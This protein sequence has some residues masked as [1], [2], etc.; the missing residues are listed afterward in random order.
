MENL[1]KLLSR[2][3]EKDLLGHESWFLLGNEQHK[4]YWYLSAGNC[5][6]G[7]LDLK[8]ESFDAKEGRGHFSFMEVD[9]LFY[10][11]GDT[12][13][14]VLIKMLTYIHDNFEDE[15][16]IESWH[17]DTE[18]GDK[19]KYLKEL[20]DCLGIMTTGTDNPDVSNDEVILPKNT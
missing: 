14:E 7:G 9:S 6:T 5:G 12:I 13:E 4:S 15:S 3:V 2:A 10:F 16:K 19:E 18:K 20:K 8:A 17:L 1:F 11:L